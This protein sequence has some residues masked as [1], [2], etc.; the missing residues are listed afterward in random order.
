MDRGR[1]GRAIPPGKRLPY[2]PLAT[3]GWRPTDERLH[4]GSSFGGNVEYIGFSRPRQLPRRRDCTPVQSGDKGQKPGKKRLLQKVLAA[5]PV[6]VSLDPA[7][8]A[9]G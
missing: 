1:Q 5:I 4:A 2:Q 7:A 3:R 6:A 9:D 8:G